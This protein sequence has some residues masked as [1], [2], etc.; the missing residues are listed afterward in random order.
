MEREGFL[1]T[2][3]NNTKILSDSKF[4][5]VINTYFQIINIKDFIYSTELKQNKV[6]IINCLEFPGSLET[7]IKTRNYVETIK[8]DYFNNKY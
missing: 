8:I 5:K 6:E 2:I 3:I 4:I 7:F 1:N